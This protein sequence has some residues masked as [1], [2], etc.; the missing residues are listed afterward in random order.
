MTPNPA[1]GRKRDV[2]AGAGLSQITS[3]DAWSREGPCHNF[4]PHE[5]DGLVFD[6]GV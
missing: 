6:C 5:M 3:Y 2:A 4:K 1:R